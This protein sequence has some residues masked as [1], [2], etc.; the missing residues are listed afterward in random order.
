MKHSI[1]FEGGEVE[2]RLV[3]MSITYAVADV[4][5]DAAMTRALSG[6]QLKEMVGLL[7]DY[8]VH[9]RIHD[10][11]AKGDYTTFDDC[12]LPWGMRAFEVVLGF[13]MPDQSPTNASS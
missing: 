7:A 3:P 1:E 2:F 8:L 5:G 9:I 12:P 13:S 11:P 10:G 6:E 4:A